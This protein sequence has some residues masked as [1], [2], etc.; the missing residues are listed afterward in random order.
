MKTKGTLRTAAGPLRL[1]EGL[2]GPAADVALYSQHAAGGRVIEA[3]DHQ[4]YDGCSAGEL[5]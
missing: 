1:L 2:R 4:G 3:R 5:G